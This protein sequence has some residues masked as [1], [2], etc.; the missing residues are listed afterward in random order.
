M[1]TDTGRKFVIDR[2]GKAPNMESL[3]RVWHQL[4]YQA[5]RDPEIQQFYNQRTAN[6]EREK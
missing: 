2:L 4:G 5:Q 3:I 6:F 1:I